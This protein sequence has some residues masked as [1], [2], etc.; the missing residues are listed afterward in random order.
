[1][2]SPAIAKFKGEIMRFLCIYKSSNPEGTPPDPQEMEQ[3]RKL[4]EE[5]K[6][7][8]VLVATEGCL[9]SAMGARVRYQKGKFVVTDGPFAESKE[10]IA[11]FALLEAKSKQEAIEHNKKF[12][13]VVGDGET[14]IRQVF[15]SGECVPSH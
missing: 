13:H 9:P 15:E 3:M 8:G 12:L 14:E 10:L 6:K 1:M 5:Q 7:S 2:S 4:V 11:G